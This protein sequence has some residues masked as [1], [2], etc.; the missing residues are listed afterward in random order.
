MPKF[1]LFNYRIYMYIQ[2]KPKHLEMFQ[3]LKHNKISFK[4]FLAAQC[5]R[6]DLNRMSGLKQKITTE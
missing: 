5:L 2:W 6:M 1:Q 4:G 3:Y